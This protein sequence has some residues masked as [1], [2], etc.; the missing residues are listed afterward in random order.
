MIEALQR[1]SDALSDISESVPGLL[2]EV[3]EENRELIADLVR[4]QLLQ[5]KRSDGSDLPNYSP[6]SVAKYGEKSGPMDLYKTGAFHRSITVRVFADYAV[7]IA[8]DRKT[9]MLERRYDTDKGK[10]VALPEEHFQDLLN[11]IIRPAL[12]DKIAAKLIA[13]INK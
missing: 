5:G 7:V 11:T 10:I 1:V 13:S 8:T 12:Q 4:L 9:E 2:G 6:V 3:L